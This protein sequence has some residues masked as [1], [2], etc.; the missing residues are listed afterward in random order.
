MTTK[1]GYKLKE[2]SKGK[3]YVIQRIGYLAMWLKCSTTKNAS[4]VSSITLDANDVNMGLNIMINL[5]NPVSNF[6][7][8]LLILILRGSGT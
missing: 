4:I 7:S 2:A 8:L 1:K 5:D 6:I 3:K